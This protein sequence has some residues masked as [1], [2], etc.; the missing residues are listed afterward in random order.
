ME[1]HSVITNYNNHYYCLPFR[2]IMKLFLEECLKKFKYMDFFYTFCFWNPVKDTSE[3]NS[4][5]GE[6]ALSQQCTA[7]IM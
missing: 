3:G 1:I 2:N 7:R 4:V 6:A 5:Q